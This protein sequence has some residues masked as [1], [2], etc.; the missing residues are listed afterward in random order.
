MPKDGV[1]GPYYLREGPLP[2]EWTIWTKQGRKPRVA[3]CARHRP[4][5]DAVELVSLLNKGTHADQLADVLAGIFEAERMYLFDELIDH[6]SFNGAWTKAR[7][8]LA[9][10][11][12][13]GNG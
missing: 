2:S 10:Y 11:R 5:E 3:L 7:A 4:R 1:P 13:H 8:A 12:G 6:A 9:D